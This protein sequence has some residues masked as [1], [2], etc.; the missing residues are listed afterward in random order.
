MWSA[1]QDEFALLSSERR[2]A[3][4]DSSAS[5]SLDALFGRAAAAAWSV[6]D[7]WPGLEYLAT[8]EGTPL[9]AREP[10]SGE[11]AAGASDKSVAVV[12]AAADAAEAAGVIS[13]NDTLEDVSTRSLRFVLL[14]YLLGVAR[15]AWQGDLSGRLDAVTDAR[16]ELLAFFQGVDNLGLLSEVDRDR[17][18]DDMPDLVQ[19]PAQ[20]RETLISRHRAEKAAIQKLETLLVRQKTH[21]NDASANGGDDADEEYERDGMLTILES[22]VRRAM[23]AVVSIDRELEVLRYAVAS[24]ARGVDPAKKAAQ[25]RPKG[26]PPG[27]GGMPGTFKIVDKRE[28]ARQGVFRPDTSIPTYTVEEWGEIEMQRAMAAEKEKRGREEVK[29][30][31]A[32]EEDSDGDEVADR[33]T[34]EARRWDN[35]KDEN[36]RGSGNSMR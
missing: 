16:K 29:A 24:Q 28:E 33:E 17:V 5:G 4:M 34:Y 26:P 21:S 15:L 36:N 12:R 20:K 8:R 27:M 7:P 18:L 35:W 32:A 19:T 14:P 31:A 22:S 11:A 6:S 1:T 13:S 3:D 23:D 2:T 9:P 30:R 10:T 25:E